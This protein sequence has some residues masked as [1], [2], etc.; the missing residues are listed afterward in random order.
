[1]GILSAKQY[2]Q[3]VK[4]VMKI[5]LLRELVNEELVKD[6]QTIK[7]L[8][9]QD[10]LQGDIFGDGRT[11]NYQSDKYANY[12]STLNPSLG[13]K[14]DLIVTGQ[15]VDAMFLKK[16]NQNRYSF[17]NTDRKR[18]ILKE[19]YGDNIFGLNQKV[20]DKYQKEIIAPRFLR[21][22]KLKANL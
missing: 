2:Q 20:F 5:T 9:E 11:Y 15:F 13:G 6:E 4:S 18:N 21:A 17:G 16:P 19:M 14:V 22:L 1:M 7:L 10:F 8:K 12:K 3:R